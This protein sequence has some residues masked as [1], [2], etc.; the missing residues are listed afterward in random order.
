[1][2][3]ALLV[4][5]AIATV[6]RAGFDGCFFESASVSTN[7]STWGSETNAYPVSGRVRQVDV[8]ASTNMT[9]RMVTSASFGTGHGGSRTALVETAVSPGPNRI[10]NAYEWVLFGDIVVFQ[11]KSAAVTGSTAYA[12]LTLEN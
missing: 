1:M 9:V 2:R 3:Y 8:W 11:H 6:A 4:L 7:T 5:L 12:T 10:T